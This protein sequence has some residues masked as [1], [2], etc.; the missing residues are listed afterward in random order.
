MLFATGGYPPYTWTLTGGRLPPGLVLNP[1]TG[2]I[3]GTPTTIAAPIV[4]SFTI[5]DSHSQSVSRTLL[6]TISDATLQITTTSLANGQTGIPYSQIL[7]VTGGTPPN[8]WEL[9][10][11]STL[12]AGLKLNSSTGEI[13]GTPAVAVD[14]TR[15]LLRVTDSGTPTPETTSTSLTLMI[16]QGTP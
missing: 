4:L 14:H 2:A 6:L 10:G 5:S 8:K 13:S 1:S 7:T 9:T 16:A 15:L 12:P 11:G 3:T